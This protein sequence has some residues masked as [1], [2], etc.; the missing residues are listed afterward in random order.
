MIKN[1]VIVNWSKDLEE[2]PFPAREGQTASIIGD[3]LYLFG[4]VASSSD[5]KGIVESDD[6]Y[7]YDIIKHIWSKKV[8][9]GDEVWPS[10]RSGACMTSH[11]E[12]LYVF[13]GLSQ[14]HG[15]FD[16]FYCFDTISQTWKRITTRGHPS[17]RDKATIC[18]QADNLFLF[19]GFCP[20][21]DDVNDEVINTDDEDGDFK[22]VVDHLKQSQEAMTFTWSNELFCYDVIKDEWESVKCFSESKP[23]PRAAHAMTSLVDD[24][25]DVKLY[26]IGGRD[27]QDR[28]NDLWQFDVKSSKWQIVYCHGYHPPAFS[29]HQMVAIDNKRLVVF[30][31]RG[32]DDQHFGDVHCLLLDSCQ[33]IQ[34]SISESSSPP[35]PMGLHS[36]CVTD[37]DV[38]LFGGSSNLNHSTGTCSTFYNSA[39]RASKKELLQGGV[40]K[41]D[42]AEQTTEADVTS[43]S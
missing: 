33:W 40:V 11:G 7:V 39:Y 8:K 15:W 18:C 16:D 23:T 10:P 27:C 9:Q 26:V 37:H 24:V 1:D 32:I 22:D 43:S 21:F 19:G 29:F 13:G 2:C 28:Q 30:G 42:Q 12:K 35:P 6:L 3:T 41:I 20:K 5:Q 17:A 31:G 25:G 38:I 36:M 14:A 4:G 34:P